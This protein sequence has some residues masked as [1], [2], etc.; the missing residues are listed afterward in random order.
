M[1]MRAAPGCEVEENMTLNADE[2]AIVRNA[3]F[4]MAKQGCHGQLHRQPLRHGRSNRSLG[5][6]AGSACRGGWGGGANLRSG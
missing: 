3:D 2:T 4:F 1:H 6:E 5:G